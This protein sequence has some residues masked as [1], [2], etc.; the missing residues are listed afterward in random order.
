MTDKP[1]EMNPHADK[2][3]ATRERIE[4]RFRNELADLESQGQLRHLEAPGGVDLNSNDYLGLATDP[5]LKRAVLEAMNSASRAA[6]TGS[7]LLS[8]QDEAWSALESEFANWVGAES[9]LY[10]TSGYAANLGLLGAILR[11]EDIVFSDSSNHASLIDGIRL[12]KC[13]RMIFPHL[14]LN[15]LEEQLRLPLPGGG[16]RVIVTES[17]FSMEGDRAPLAEM[18]ALADRYGAE[19]IVD[20]AH[21]VG[22]CGPK[23]SGCVAEAGLAGQVL[24]TVHTCGK[25]L[26]AAGAFVCGSE[27]LRQILINRARSFIFNTALP[28]YFAAQ[29]SAGMRLAADAEEERR[30][31]NENSACLRDALRHNAFDI[32]ASSSH[33]VPVILGANETAVAFAAHLRTRGFG[34]RAIRPPTVPPGSA[35]LRLSL[36]AKLSQETLADLGAAMNE[37]REQILLG[38]SA[39]GRI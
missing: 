28:P 21:A 18:L 19:L 7:R 8:G 26:A 36:T 37:A 4:E 3:S 11:D 32:A 34:A 20:E 23:G 12:A 13:R 17:I 27:E 14:D 29:V 30:R 38:Q 22:V 31:L 9:A 33:I 1:G 15:V 2:E 10:F 39:S 6:S 35:R 25:A 16:M 5:R 24:A